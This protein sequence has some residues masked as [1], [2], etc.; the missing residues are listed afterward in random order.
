MSN[1][2]Y[3]GTCKFRSRNI[4]EHVNFEQELLGRNHLCPARDVDGPKRRCFSVIAISLSAALGNAD[5][6][7]E[8][9][10]VIEHP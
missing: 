3:P 4:Q 6:V 1:Q 7:E 8:A 2:E 5:V 9:H 10:L